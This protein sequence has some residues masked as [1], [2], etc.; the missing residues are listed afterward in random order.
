MTSSLYKTSA[1]KYCTVNKNTQINKIKI[2]KIELF[3]LELWRNVDSV[4]VFNDV[5]VFAAA[6]A[7]A[8]AS[9]A[10]LHSRWTLILDGL[11][12]LLYMPHFCLQYSLNLKFSD[13]IKERKFNLER[14]ESFRKKT[15]NRFI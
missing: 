8:A 5:D 7:F 9:T 1:S 11:L 13:L 14:Y 4:H 3:I 2:Q 12:L 6:D 10:E 15:K